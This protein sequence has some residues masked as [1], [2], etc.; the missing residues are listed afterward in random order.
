MP[1]IS[2]PALR[3][4][5]SIPTWVLS[6]TPSVD[7][8]FTN[9]RYWADGSGRGLQ[10]IDFLS[11]SRASTGYVQSVGG[12]LYNCGNN[13]LRISDQGLLIEEARTNLIT[14]SQALDNAAWTKT[15]NSISADST[16]APDGTAT[17]DTITDDSTNAAHYL[18]NA[19]SYTNTTTYVISGY[20]KAGTDNLIQLTIGSGVGGAN[21]YANFQLTGSGSVTATGASVTVSGIQ[22][23]A[24]GWYRCWVGGAATA[25]SSSTGIIN[26]INSTGAARSPSY[27]GTGT[28]V[29]SWGMQVEAGSFPTSY[30]PTTTTSATRAADNVT[31]AGALQTLTQSPL[32][33]VFKTAP[34]G[35]AYSSGTNGLFGY[36]SQN[37]GVRYGT[38]T[39]AVARFASTSV[40][41]T[42]GGSGSIITDTVKV[43]ASWDASSESVVANNGTVATGSNAVTTNTTVSIGAMSGSVLWLNGYLQRSSFWNS[44]LP[45]ATLKAL[46]V[47]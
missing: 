21:I 6:P 46:T 26:R 25:T 41:A 37:Q 23:L 7:M 11:C 19:V 35:S 13:Q 27:V 36:A 40:S 9:G 38:N 29:I 14:Q 15:N 28:T 3:I 20:F 18:S 24:N 1:I 5:N 32:S 47:P 4:I 12:I 30:I 8:D 43:G 34:L 33:V 10:A 2:R 45:D 39:T 31:A 42:I 44:R 16:N 22:S 17:A